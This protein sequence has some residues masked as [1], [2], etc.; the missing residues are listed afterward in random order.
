MSIDRFERRDVSRFGRGL[1]NAEGTRHSRF[2]QLTQQGFALGLA[3]DRV[4]KLTRID[5]RVKRRASDRH[6]LQRLRNRE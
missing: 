6:D 3:R 4:G 1:R 5:Q 2:A